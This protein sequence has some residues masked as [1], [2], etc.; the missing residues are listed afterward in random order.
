MD[1]F[2]PR[3]GRRRPP[4]PEPALPLSPPQPE[5][6]PTTLVIEYSITYN[7]TTID[8]LIK[9]V[10]ARNPTVIAEIDDK[11][12][13]LRSKLAKCRTVVDI[14][15]HRTEI[16]NLE[17]E[18]HTLA[19]ERTLD[20]YVK[21]SA[22]L[23]ERFV[24]LPITR[25]VVG[26]TDNSN[27]ERMT[28]A[29]E[30][31]KSIVDEYL[32]VAKRYFPITINYPIIERPSPSSSS[33]QCNSCYKIISSAKCSIRGNII[34]NHCK[35]E[36]RVSTTSTTRCGKEYDVYTNL[37]KSINR[38]CCIQLIN[39]DGDILVKQLDEYFSQRGMPTS[40]D[41]K[42]I[43]LNSNGRK[44][45]T[46]HTIITKAMGELGYKDHYKNY[47]Y[48]CHLYFGW[49]RLDDIS[50]YIPKIEE[51]FRATQYVW[52]YLMTPAEKEGRTSSL[53]VEYRKLKHYQLLFDCD[54][55][56]VDLTTTAKTINQYDRIWRIMCERA[57]HPEIKYIPT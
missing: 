48:V 18:Q 25:K 46:D 35:A 16:A 13:N 47:L 33:L 41:Y 50:R 21:E 49:S 30:L 51:H 14:R 52:D 7:I 10:L 12:T 56:M 23:I 8:T 17:K 11:L 3:Q 9:K 5:V 20:A 29:E 44:D 34:C 22:E 27:I 43:P 19:T 39:F 42:L 57:N 54:K 55:N 31:K 37:L 53:P 38:D 40:K 15:Q 28:P 26:M 45:G 6:L 24:A 4:Q 36:N 2:Q 32:S 1:I